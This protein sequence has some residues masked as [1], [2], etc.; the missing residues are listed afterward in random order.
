[1]QL[2]SKI[3]ILCGPD[4]QCHRWTDRQTDRRHVIARLRFAL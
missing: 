2:V 4:H 3:F 1:M